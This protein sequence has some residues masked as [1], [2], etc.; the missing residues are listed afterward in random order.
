MGLTASAGLARG[1]GRALFEHVDKVM[2]DMRATPSKYLAPLLLLTL[3][4]ACGDDS[5]SSA[6]DSSSDGG[7]DAT[8]S[9]SA[10]TT[11]GT[12]GASGTQTT[13]GNGGS[14]SDSMTGGT[15][16]TTESP[17]TTGSMTSAGPGTSTDPG[18][19]TG[20]TS[21]ATT[22][23]TE[24]GAT[25]GMMPLMCPDEPDPGFDG[26]SDPE[27]ASEEQIGTFSPVVEWKKTTWNVSPGS[28]DVGST[29]IVASMNDDNNDG[30]INEDDIPDIVVVTW[31]PAVL[32]VISGADGAEILNIT[33]ETFSNQSGI[34]VG[35]IDGDNMPEIIVSV[36]TQLK[37]FEHDGS[38]KWNSQVYSS[39]DVGSNGYSWPAISDMDAD[40]TPEIVYGRV[41]LNNDGTQRGVGAHGSGSLIGLAAMSFAVDLDDDGVQ[42]VVTGNALYTPDGDTIWHNNLPD[43]APAVA[44][45]DA[46]GTPE[47]VVVGAATLRLQSSVD[48]SSIWS[49]PIP[50]ANNRGGAPT[51]ADFDGDG[52]PE[53]GVAGADF[54]LVFD[55]DGSILWQHAVN[56]A[57]SAVTGSSVYD[58]E[59]DGVADVVYADQDNLWVLPGANGDAKLQFGEHSS[60]T[61]FE[62]PI[63]A[64][65]DGDDQVE[66]VYGSQGQFSG[67]TVIGDAEES[68]R[69][70]R[71][72]WN[73]YDYHITNINDDGSI[74]QDAGLNWLSYNNFRS[75]DLSPSDGQA[76][77]D[78]A[79]GNEA[80]CEH[81]CVDG[82]LVLTAQL[83]NE[84]ASALTAGGEVS[85]FVVINGEEMLVETIELDGQIDPGVWLDGYLFEL[86]PE[87]VESIIL[88][89]SANEEEC[90]L[91]NNELVI[92]GPFCDG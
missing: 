64:D 16:N 21:E 13:T 26:E 67:I 61:W 65:I 91:D 9:E 32:R 46:D 39:A 40:G 60:G 30:M 62:Y 84:G 4:G 52:A 50:N 42:E 89:A 33:G 79:L 36:S 88:R 80:V 72:V 73:Q 14:E 34:A 3:A 41:I 57:S 75:G 59:G 44:D 90:N 51:I 78:L 69:P 85:L 70:G 58:F 10:G 28:D 17:E 7:T 20:T 2:F 53:I 12:E 11:A 47:I 86:D 43:G 22:D 63:I 92:A 24:T 31:G 23:A 54:Y 18:T 48:G 1:E 38:P 55:T 76:A 71:E 6:S 45:F 87:G 29:P 5:A 15:G 56:D 82:L 19:S 8:E 37:A 27:C 77:P 25:T 49:V 74:P 68:W 83:G 66:I 81:E 35:D